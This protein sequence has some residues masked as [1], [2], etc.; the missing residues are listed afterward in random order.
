MGRPVHERRCAN[1]HTWLDGYVVPPRQYA[2][3][4]GVRFCLDC[5]RLR[6]LLLEQLRQRGERRER[7]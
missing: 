5:A 6:W 3:R 4:K 2:P 7:A 1:C